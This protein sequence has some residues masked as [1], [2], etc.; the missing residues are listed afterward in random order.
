[1]DGTVLVGARGA[2]RQVTG[3]SMKCDAKE[4]PEPLSGT[5]PSG[6]W[7]AG[8]CTFGGKVRPGGEADRLGEPQ[9][10]AMQGQ[11]A[12]A[13]CGDRVIGIMSPMTKTG[14]AIWWSW[15]MDTLAVSAVG[16]QGLF[17]KRPQALKLDH[18][19]GVDASDGDT[20]VFKGVSKLFRDSGRF[21]TG[22]ESS[23][24]DALRQTT[25]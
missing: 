14:Q 4:I 2:A 6:W 21:Q 12:L 23:L 19:G 13:V 18:N 11:A 17:K 20:L 3:L 1:M 24:F 5:K 15:P 16:S 9:E 22:Q 25:A 8:E 7:L 10:G